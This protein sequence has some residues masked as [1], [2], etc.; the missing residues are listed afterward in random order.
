[1]AE[2]LSYRVVTYGCQMNVHDS[3]RISGLLD[4]AGYIPVKQDEAADVIVFN[5]CAVRENADNRLYGNLSH[6]VPVKAAKP[7]IPVIPSI[8]RRV[9]RE[10][11]SSV[12]VM[13]DES[14]ALA[15]ISIGVFFIM[16]I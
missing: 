8:S 5:T 12:S 7:A 9:R 13:G 4:A 14:S 15:A 11:G 10:F 1:M 3:E 2:S 16:I 6:L